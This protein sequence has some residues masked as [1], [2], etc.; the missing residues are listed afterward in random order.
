MTTDSGLAN[1]GPLENETFRKQYYAPWFKN[2][3]TT[4]GK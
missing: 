3:N 1:F 4:K 2:Y